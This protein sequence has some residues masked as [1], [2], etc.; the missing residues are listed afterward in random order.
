M[1]VMRLLAVLAV[2]LASGVLALSAGASTTSAPAAGPC[3]PGTSYDPACDVDHNGVIDITDIQLTAG[4]WDQSGP[5]TSDNDHEHLDQVWSRSRVPLKIQSNFDGTG[6][7]RPAALVLT[8][9]RTGLPGHGLWVDSVNGNGVIV[10][11]AGTGVY[12][13]TAANDGVYVCT[14]GSAVG[15]TASTENNGVEVGNAEGNGVFVKNAGNDGVVVDA[16]ADS[17][18][19]INSAGGN[20]LDLFSAG[21]DGVRVLNAGGDGVHVTLAQGDGVDATT[22][23]LTGYGGRFSNAATSGAGVYTIGGS[24]SAPDLVLGGNN[25]NSDDGRIYSQPE[26]PS[27]DIQ[28]HT[29]DTVFIHLDEDDNS[30]SAVIIY[31]GANNEI[32]SVYESGLAVAGEGN[33]A[34]V[35]AGEEGRQLV[36]GVH[37]PQNWLEDFGSGRLA[38]GAAVVKVDNAFARAAN[39]EASYHVFLTPLGDCALYVADKGAASFTVRALGGQACDVGFDYRI[40]ALRRG[41]ESSRM[42]EFV[43]PEDH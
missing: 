20:G 35:D 40:V 26:F 18:V 37:S 36:Y 38:A 8:N 23:S 17:G 41:Y 32:W 31:D 42:P 10:N 34:V 7:S 13:N 43:T 27:S 39:L 4:H 11:S 9:T 1:K 2:V 24:N 5:W 12:V 30:L 29:M 25:I 28:L 22:G 21:G 33:A 15:C 3:A 19:V 16:A 14:T 6:G